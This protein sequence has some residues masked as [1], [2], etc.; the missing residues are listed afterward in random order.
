MIYDVCRLKLKNFEE[1]RPRPFRLKIHDVRLF[2]R[3][4]EVGNHYDYYDCNYF[5]ITKCA[6]HIY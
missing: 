6:L 4:P 1:K 2:M 3:S 5:M